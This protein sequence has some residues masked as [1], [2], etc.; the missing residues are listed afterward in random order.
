LSCDPE[1]VTAYVDGALDEA[2]R[3][4]IEAHLAGCATCREQEGFER[5]L[6]ARLQALPPV[7]PPPGLEGRLRR[8]LR[9]RSPL[10]FVLP[11]AAALLL[12]LW[13]RGSSPFVAWELA[14][15]HR[16]CFGKETLP[17]QVWSSDPQAVA[18]WFESQ[19]TQ[20]P[21]IPAAA[22]GLDLVG[23]RH[24]PLPDISK[25]AHVYYAGT[26]RHLSLYVVPRKLRGE[27]GWSGVAGGQVVSVLR[28]GGVQV[29]LVGDTR[30]DV[31]AFE[32]ALSTRVASNAS[33]SAP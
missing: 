9:R 8:R 12:A 18:R 16:H 25:V 32:R 5:G 7:E 6:R 19:G 14:L 31:T 22:A 3:A 10:R 21:L 33:A 15:D 24:C 27:S 2:Q 17:A 4:E 30:D 26:A 11:L 13:V 23:A 20:L 29:A 28:A 1:R